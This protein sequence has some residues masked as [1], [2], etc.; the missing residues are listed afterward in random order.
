MLGRNQLKS[1]LSS[2]REYP[3]V[4]LKVSTDI[5]KWDNQFMLKKHRNYGDDKLYSFNKC[6]GLF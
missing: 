4:M 1:T 2:E 3:M 5:D 6:H